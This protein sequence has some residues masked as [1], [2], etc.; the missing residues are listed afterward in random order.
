MD[1]DPNSDP[2]RAFLS[3]SQHVGWGT[4]KMKM[5]VYRRKSTWVRVINTRIIQR[6]IPHNPKVVGS[7][8]AA[9]TKI[10]TWEPVRE[11]SMCSDRFSYTLKNVIFHV[12]L[13]SVAFTKHLSFISGI[14]VPFE[15]FSMIYSSRFRI[16][17]T[18]KAHEVLHWYLYQRG[19]LPCLCKHRS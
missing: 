19:L 9:A 3:A 5:T 14:H 17:Y 13:L 1:F 16:T 8:P 7:N 4:P 2:L 6:V 12:R 18:F 10:I 11:H 15:D